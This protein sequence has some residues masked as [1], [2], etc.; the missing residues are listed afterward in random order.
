MLLL[1]DRGA[2]WALVAFSRL[3]PLSSSPSWAWFSVALFV[4]LA[5]EEVGS[6]SVVAGDVVVLA[7][8]VVSSSLGG[9]LFEPCSVDADSVCCT[10]AG[11]FS[12]GGAELPFSVFCKNIA[13]KRGAQDQ[14]TLLLVH[15]V[16]PALCVG[17]VQFIFKVAVFTRDNEK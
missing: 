3:L 9:V 2:S 13:M 8:F 5:L 15:L 11:C 4:E 12:S 1:S 17:C 14:Q 16:R 6:L 7:P 10:L